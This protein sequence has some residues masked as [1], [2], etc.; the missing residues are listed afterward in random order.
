MNVLQRINLKKTLFK[1][2]HAVGMVLLEET[3]FRDSCECF[4]CLNLST[5][6]AQI[7]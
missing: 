5:D 7:F 2:R 6:V 1:S 4:N 3:L